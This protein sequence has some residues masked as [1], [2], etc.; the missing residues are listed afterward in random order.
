MVAGDENEAFT[1]AVLDFLSV[2]QRSFHQA[3]TR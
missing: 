3:R 2:R 1:A